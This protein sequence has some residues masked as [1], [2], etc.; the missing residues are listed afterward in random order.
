MHN[1]NNQFFYSTLVWFLGVCSRMGHLQ[2]PNE[3]CNYLRQNVDVCN[4]NGWTGSMCIPFY[5]GDVAPKV[6]MLEC[7]AC[8]S[9]NVCITTFILACV[10]PFHFTGDVTCL[11]SLGCVW[12]PCIKM[13][14]IVNRWMLLISVLQRKW[15][16]QWQKLCHCCSNNQTFLSRLA[17]QDF[18]KWWQ[19]SPLWSI[20]GGCYGKIHYTSISQQYKLCVGFEEICV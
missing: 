14:H 11:H 10:C 4:S 9:I 17:S 6:Y 15:K 18:V 13:V 1:Q 16:H 19:P 3:I 7:K 20:L 5:V 2:C 8:H 12:S